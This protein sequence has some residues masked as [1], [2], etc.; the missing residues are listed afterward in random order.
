MK[1]K[2]I[3]S[4]AELEKLRLKIENYFYSEIKLV[5]CFDENYWD[6][7]NSKGRIDGF[8]VVFKNNRYRLE[9]RGA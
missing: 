1:N 5:Q 7:H 4:H 3:G 9:T 8:S 2:L 6:I